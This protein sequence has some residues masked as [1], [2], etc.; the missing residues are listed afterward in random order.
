LCAR[1]HHKPPPKL[2]AKAAPSAATTTSTTTGFAGLL[3][4]A[5]R[6]DTPAALVDMERPG[7]IERA[8][9]IDCGMGLLRRWVRKPTA[10]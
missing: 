1:Y 7:E 3:G 2:T 10:P 9:A 6:S 4:T 8:G 5:G